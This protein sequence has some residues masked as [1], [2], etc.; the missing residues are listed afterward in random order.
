MHSFCRSLKIISFVVLLVLGVLMLHGKMLENHGDWIHGDLGDGRLNALFLEHNFQFLT[1]G[2]PN[3]FW[4]TPWMFHPMPNGLAMSDVMTGNLPTYTL[5]RSF[6]TDPM[7]A[8]QIWFVITSILNCVSF[9][10]L[11][12]VLKLPSLPGMMG[13]FLF[14]FSLP[15]AGF[16]YHAQLLPQF[17]T[18]LC[19]AFLALYFRRDQDIRRRASY[20][21]AA[22]ISFAWQ[23]WCGFYFGWF[24]AFGGLV[25]AI[26][27]FSRQHTRAWLFS[28][29]KQDWILWGVVGI[30]TAG[31]I[32]PLGWHYLQMQTFLGSFSFTDVRG[33]LPRINHI[34]L[35][36][37]GSLLYGAFYDSIASTHSTPYEKMMFAGF[38]A[39]LTPALILYIEKKQ[40]DGVSKSTRL[41]P[42][43]V[44]FLGA[45]FFIVLGLS[46]NYGGGIRPW[47]QVYMLVPGAGGI[48][49]VGRI[50]FLLLLPMSLTL[51][52]LLTYLSRSSKQK[53]ILSI[54]LSGII[55]VENISV[56]KP[57]F[58]KNIHQQRVKEVI[59]QLDEK[60]STSGNCA[61]FYY[62]NYSTQENG[63]ED[64]IDGMWASLLTHKPLI[65]GYSSTTPRAFAS[66]GLGNN[67][68]PLVASIVKWGS[69][70]QQEWRSEN[71]CI[72]GKL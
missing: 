60:Q 30:L 21:F 14:A 51:V 63:H 32:A 66:L 71:I 3:T 25:A 50:I 38:V 29:L 27:C 7:T 49:A 72:I 46:L 12:R 6:V 19:L 62:E 68:F 59:S 4:D 8:Y 45:F 11:T 5:A 18:A 43:L 47:N 35:A 40:R 34:F 23:F 15:R 57:I 56:P 28:H 42:E 9:F 36:P 41:H 48:R 61:F 52:C 70:F 33:Y 10:W 26:W 54:L 39:L 24:L 64:R 20:L 44:L 31:L 2:W 53:L 1:S 65:N 69:L 55:F 13:A 16:L 17:P 22:A 58:S 67:E 37:S